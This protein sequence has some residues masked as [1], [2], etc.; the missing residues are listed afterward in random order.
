MIPGQKIYPVLWQ[1]SKVL[2]LSLFFY[3]TS[4]LWNSLSPNLQFIANKHLFKNNVK[5]HLSET[6]LAVD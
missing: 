3:S 5:T 1:V 6:L 4:K 2:V